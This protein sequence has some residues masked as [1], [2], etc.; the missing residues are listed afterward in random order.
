M[1]QRVRRKRRPSNLPQFRR[2]VRLP[3]PERL[4]EEEEQERSHTSFVSLWLFLR[5]LGDQEPALV[6]IIQAMSE[7]SELDKIDFPNF[8]SRLRFVCSCFRG[9]L[10]LFFPL[11][12]HCSHSTKST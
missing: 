2:V 10:I 4:E 1:E 5:R 11:S 3:S 9:S 7:S 6:D 8:A 12:S